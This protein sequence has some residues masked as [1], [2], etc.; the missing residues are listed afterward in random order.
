[1]LHIFAVIK[2]T[3]PHRFD[4]LLSA[5]L[6]TQWRWIVPVWVHDGWAEESLGGV[7]E[8]GALAPGKG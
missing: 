6:L 3:I 4:L 8:A 5:L 1:M 7:G 2:D